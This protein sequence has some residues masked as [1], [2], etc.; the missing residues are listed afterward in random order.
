MSGWSA[1]AKAN[2]V[3]DLAE[4]L[5]YEP[6]R[7]GRIECPQ[8]RQRHSTGGRTA[9]IGKA[10]RVIFC[11]KGCSP[12]DC[13]GL[14]K[15]HNSI[16]G[17][18]ELHAE[19]AAL[20]L[21][22]PPDGMPDDAIKAMQRRSAA[23]RRDMAK[24]KA[25]AEAAD[26]AARN[27]PLPDIAGLIASAR[28]TTERSTIT[29]YARDVRRFPA[30]IADAIAADPDG[31][32]DATD[33]GWRS[34][35]AG[36]RV[37]AWPIRGADG[38]IRSAAM[39]RSDGDRWHTNGPKSLSLSNAQAGPT[40]RWPGVELAD[41]ERVECRAFGSIPEAVERAIDAKA[42]L[43]L[44]EGEIDTIAMRA[45]IAAEGMPDAVIGAQGVAQLRKIA[46]V[47]E[48]CAKGRRIRIATIPDRDGDPLT[49]TAALDALKAIRAR[50]PDAEHLD[51]T[52]RGDDLADVMAADGGV[53]ELRQRI[54]LLRR[55]PDA[56]PR[57]IPHDAA[58]ADRRLPDLDLAEM[59]G[60]ATVIRA[61]MGTGKTWQGARLAAEVREAGGIVLAIAPLVSV[62]GSLSKRVDV[63]LYSKMLGEISV[64]AAFCVNSIGRYN[65][66]TPGLLIIDEFEQVM[67]SICDG[68]V[69]HTA[70]ERGAKIG[71]GILVSVDVLN[72]LYRLIV[73]TIDAGGAVMICDAYLSDELLG[74]LRRW[75]RARVNL[76]E[77]QVAA[78]GRV[79]FVDS[80]NE[81]L[82]MA[83]EAAKQ[84]RTIG[85]MTDSAGDVGAIVQA[86][87]EA[88]PDGSSARGYTGD[89]TND[90]KADL[91]DPRR[92]WGADRRDARAVVCSPV[93]KSAVDADA[94]D[95]VFVESKGTIDA[96]AAMQ[97]AGRFRD[98]REIVVWAA[99]GC[100]K[101]KRPTSYAAVKA[102]FMAKHR[103]SIAAQRYAKG[104]AQRSPT[105]W[106]SDPADDRHLEMCIQVER[107]A[108]LRSQ[109]PRRQL[110]ALFAAAGYQV[111]AAEPA[112]KAASKAAKD[113]RADAKKTIRAA[114]NAAIAT[115]KPLSAIEA[116]RIDRGAGFAT[117][118]ELHSAE[119]T[120]LKR[121]HG[122]VS[123]ALAEADGGRRLKAITRA[124]KEI[125]HAALAHDAPSELAK[126]DARNLAS[127][128]GASQKA[129]TRR[130]FAVKALLSAALG[131]HW[132]TLAGPPDAAARLPSW[133]ADTITQATVDELRAALT[134]SESG[135]HYGLNEATGL[136]FKPKDL[137]SP[138]GVVKALGELLRRW[139]LDT[140][141]QRPRV[142]GRRVRRYSVDP[143]T[144]RR[145]L[146]WVAPEHARARGVACN[147]LDPS[148]PPPD[149]A[150]NAEGDWWIEPNSYSHKRNPR[151]V[152]VLDARG[153]RVGWIHSSLYRENDNKLRCGSTP[154]RAAQ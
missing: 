17:S 86:L 76:I 132:Q 41:G 130:A 77:H 12:I 109:E 89:S 24:A 79:R 154:D 46:A 149:R 137:K 92:A 47:V 80:K 64:S 97:M 142:D 112:S 45:F 27:R 82:A 22:D 44:V 37:L 117:A 72:V 75:T 78:S 19:C 60:R 101:G 56:R 124:G 128:G 29:A 116:K 151:R 53:D 70:T 32:I 35:P 50:F 55:F 107:L 103:S 10:G 3:G 52:D 133:G 26:S 152:P 21:C 83:V 131:N 127:G 61:S 11:R 54:A 31:P 25:K 51:L 150:T 94:R 59:L 134:D 2:D 18:R 40:A 96:V 100:A 4:R 135:M 13:V 91:D 123:I 143:E 87:S 48:H 126:I 43:W 81:L 113:A 98:S 102:E 62:A 57:T 129:I 49:R 74:E 1:A 119:H 147:G 33:L 146:Q 88:Y 9:Y 118:A 104:R 30:A 105:S 66:P 15:L 42:R 7:R 38:E 90:R 58:E 73:T 114:E 148:A 110:E 23:A 14:V 6:P 16:T 139:R 108:R 99:K 93:V 122:E 71:D 63:P 34:A 85:Y 8:C 68:T 106:A 36:V 121:A 28:S 125:A 144:L 120:R 95:F 140:T 141:M 115:A 153:L 5:G 138:A 84:D 111:E 20:G 39:R 65:G 145:W 136:G 67:G 69:P